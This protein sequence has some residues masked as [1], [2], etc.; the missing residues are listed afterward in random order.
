MTRQL[1]LTA[2]QRAAQGHDGQGAHQA[3]L[4]PSASGSISAAAERR[5]HEHACLLGMGSA[6][7]PVA[8]LTQVHG[9]Q[10]AAAGLNAATRRA[11]QWPVLCLLAALCSS[12]GAN[13]MKIAHGRRIGG[14]GWAPATKTP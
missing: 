5:M 11:D 6:C 7:R 14:H 4:S 1:Y 9:A 8:E 12:P 2:V 10:A 3:M 13:I